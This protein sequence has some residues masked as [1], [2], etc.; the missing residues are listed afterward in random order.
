MAAQDNE[1]ALS[2]EVLQDDDNFLV[3]RILYKGQPAIRKTLKSSIDARRRSTFTNEVDG[4]LAFCD[5]LQQA[6]GGFLEVP[7]ILEAGEDSYI[8]EYVAG[9]TLAIAIEK[10]TADQFLQV[11]AEGLAD[12]D[13]ILPQKAEEKEIDSAPY[14]NIRKRT[15]EWSSV[16]VE[17]GLLS[18]EEVAM[19]N[20]IIDKYEDALTPRY[21]HG[22][23]NPLKHCFLNDAGKISLI[24]L[25]H[26]SALKPRYYDAAYCFTRVYSQTKVAGLAG[27]FL[28]RF[29]NSS[30][31]FS[32]QQMIAILM[33]R[34][35]GLCFD[36]VNDAKQGFD[37]TVKAKKFFDLCLDEDL[38][39]ILKL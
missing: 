31:N 8:R 7:V 14:K 2:T 9:E 15:G 1:Q 23:I 21:A 38:E 12:I 25:E 34:A 33:Q 29:I 13:K 10:G 19:A 5:I 26:F 35:I 4:T 24:D 22:D 28:E 6:S 39:A 17:Y 36:S 30:D 37:Y 27:R 32:N 3:E 18:R 16:A 11:L 20:R